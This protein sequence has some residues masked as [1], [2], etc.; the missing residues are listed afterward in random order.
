MTLGTWIT[1]VIVLWLASEIRL[2]VTRRSQS[3]V[4]PGADRSSLRVLWITITLAMFAGAVLSRFRV[5][6]LP[7]DGRAWAI[8]G[9]ALILL[10]ILVRWIAIVTL[11]RAFTVDVA[12]APGQDV[13]ERG[14]YRRI[15][16]PSYTGSLLSCL[17]MGLVFGN[18]LSL[19][20][21]LAPITLAF[22]YR[23]RVEEA[24]LRAAFGDAYTRYSARSWRILP[25]IY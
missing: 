24:A 4:A 10:G 16:H 20:A 7:G 25:F 9:L 12:I 5:G 15:R 13:V 11:A 1:I 23:I 6:V 21:V 8:A 22:L 14:I 18:A 17:G 3:N 19:V 2:A